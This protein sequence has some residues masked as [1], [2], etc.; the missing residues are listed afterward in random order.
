MLLFWLFRQVFD[1][2]VLGDTVKKCREIAFP[3]NFRSLLCPAVVAVAHFAV[4]VTQKVY[5][6]ATA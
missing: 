4:A 6:K 2:K 3:Y 5:P 1:R